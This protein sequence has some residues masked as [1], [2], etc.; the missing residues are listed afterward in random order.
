VGL[1]FPVSGGVGHEKSEVQRVLAFGDKGE[2]GILEIE[3]CPGGVRIFNATSE[4]FCPPANRGGH[5]GY[6]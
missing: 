1:S 3:L 4:V 6:G 2:G 5:I